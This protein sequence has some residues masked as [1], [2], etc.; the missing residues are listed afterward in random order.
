MKNNLNF[1]LI[2]SFLRDRKY[3]VSIFVICFLSMYLLLNFAYM[4]KVTSDMT[5]NTIENDCGYFDVLVANVTE[6][7]VKAIVNESYVC[8]YCTYNSFCITDNDTEFEV[9]E[10]DESYFKLS[11]HYF[12]E[13]KIPEKD[14]EIMCEPWYLRSKGIETSKMIGSSLEIAGKTYVVTGLFV[15]KSYVIEDDASPV[16]LK[17]KTSAINRLLINIEGEELTKAKYD[18][19][20]KVENKETTKVYGNVDKEMIKEETLNGTIG[21]IAFVF[22]VLAISTIIILINFIYLFVNQVYKRINVYCFLGIARNKISGAAGTVLGLIIVFANMVALGVFFVTSKLFFNKIVGEEQYNYTIKQAMN[23]E[24]LILFLGILV[25]E[26]SIILSILMKL[27]WSKFFRDNGKVRGVYDIK[28]GKKGSKHFCFNMAVNGLKISRKINILTVL[29]ISLSIIALSSVQYYIESVN[30][31][32]IDYGDTKYIIHMYEA[33]L[34]SDEE[35]EEINKFVDKVL[36][37]D[38]LNAQVQNIHTDSV[39]VAKKQLSKPLEKFLKQF[40]RYSAVLENNFT[41]NVP[42]SVGLVSE[43]D[44]KDYI[45][46][47][48][49]DNEVILFNSFINTDITSALNVNIGDELSVRHST[50]ILTLSIKE[51][52]EEFFYQVYTNDY[53]CMMIVNEDTFN[54]LSYN[55]VP[56]EIFIKADVPESVIL[57]VTKDCS[58][59]RVEN[60]AFDRQTI[61]EGVTM[62]NLILD[63]LF[64]ICLVV[65]V[66][67]LTTTCIIRIMVF[68]KEYATLNAIGISVGTI[69]KIPVYEFLIILVPISIISVLG[70]F[71]STLAIHYNVSEYVSIAYEFPIDNF[72]RIWGILLVVVGICVIVAADKIRHQTFQKVLGENC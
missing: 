29:T 19:L 17:K 15:D 11:S 5:E 12:I 40:S 51:I 23:Q 24:C 48:L 9:L 46:V 33:T 58:F 69:M 70:S 45:D 10:V 27:F 42:V 13:G 16:I 20:S 6:K 67:N 72:V 35:E 14:N 37:N 31:D 49:K 53:M 50:E 61:S 63:G 57:D 8:E 21:V 39:I 7:D 22:V 64:I 28:S 44:V 59:V 65:I 41:K 1:I 66:I 4:T 56:K 38:M 26:L 52:R 18:I 32:L 47:E 60:V 43:E 71:A 3:I 62:I 34:P 30:A 25:V 68:N 54:M 36:E 2:K 55:Q